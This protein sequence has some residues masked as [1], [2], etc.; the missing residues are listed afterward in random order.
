MGTNGAVKN[1]CPRCG[2]K[3]RTGALPTGDERRRLE[4]LGIIDLGDPPERMECPK[5]QTKLKVV[6]VRMG[7]FFTLE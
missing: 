3:F 2:V 7:S 6:S 5:C 4:K 1:G